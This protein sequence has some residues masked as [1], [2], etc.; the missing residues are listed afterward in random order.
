MFL[1]GWVRTIVRDVFRPY[2]PTPAKTTGPL[3]AVTPPLGSSVT[4]ILRSAPGSIGCLAIIIADPAESGMKVPA[5]TG[6]APRGI[7]H[8]W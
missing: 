2:L 1:I 7:S 3:G 4:A 5:D 8:T 6:A